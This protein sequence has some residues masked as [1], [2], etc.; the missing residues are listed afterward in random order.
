MRSKREASVEEL[1]NLTGDLG[2]LVQTLRNDPKELARKERRWRLLYGGLSAVGALLAR[3]L[4]GKA[5]G[6]LTGERPPG[7]KK[8][9]G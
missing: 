3:R 6:V 5:W 8:S 1:R 2:S 7:T 4:A 9:K